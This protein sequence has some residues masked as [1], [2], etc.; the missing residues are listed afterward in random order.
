MLKRY[1]VLLED[2]QADYLK[3]AAERYDLSFSEMLRAM[4]CRGALATIGEVQPEYKGKMDVKYLREKAN[5][6]NKG[7][8]DQEMLHKLLSELYFETRKAIEYRTSKAKK[9]PV[10]SA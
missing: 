2:W 8:I 5:A 1:Q 7:K 10:I 4:L 3:A 9:T 6:L